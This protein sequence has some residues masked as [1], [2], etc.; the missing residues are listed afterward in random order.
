M[1]LARTTRVARQARAG[2]IVI[3][4]QSHAKSELRKW[5][6]A[7][8][9]TADSGT[10]R[11]EPNAE[12]RDGARAGGRPH[13]DTGH[14]THSTDARPRQF[15]ARTLSTNQVRVAAKISETLVA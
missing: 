6:I 10:L 4:E 7:V 15:L 8:H 9:L 3:T 5:Q 1:A 11:R 14:E 2:K 13:F 12:D